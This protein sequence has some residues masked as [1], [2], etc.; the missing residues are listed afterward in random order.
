M[1]RH[2]GARRQLR[3]SPDRHQEHGDLDPNAGEEQRPPVDRWLV[4][5]SIMGQVG[6]PRHIQTASRARNEAARVRHD[7]RR[8]IGRQQGRR[9][10]PM[11]KPR[12]F[13]GSSGKQERLLQSLVR[14]LEDIA[15][16]QPWTTSFNPGVNTLDR[17]IELS[18][19][20]DF[21]VFLFAQDDWTSAAPPDTAAAGTAQASPRDNVV[22]EAGLFGSALGLRRTFILHAHGSK[23]PTDLLGLTSVRYTD[24]SS[25]A[26][27]RAI[28]QKLRKAIEDEGRLARIEGYWWQFS[29]TERTEHEPSAVSLLRISRDR[30]G[31]LEVNGRSWQENGRQSARY[32][33]K[34]SKERANPSGIFYYWRGERPRDPNA[35]ELQ[36]TGEILTEAADSAAGYFTTHSDTDP[37]VHARTSGIY[38]RAQP[39]DVK[40][41][42][43]GDDQARAALIAERLA[44]WKAI[45][46]A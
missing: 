8:A 26:E 7:E 31:D 32:W 4:H 33:S 29:L 17:L 23:L 28:N 18:H 20:V 12:V 13:L 1:D 3:P 5:E 34:A 9:E 19:E 37:V 39:D 36:G 38:R 30:D 16:V 43:E 24:A 15:D 11:G 25:A 21:A 40:I 6:R 35:P 2:L 27:V 42:D 22:F 45:V 41:L 14:G 10:E 46:E 44:Q